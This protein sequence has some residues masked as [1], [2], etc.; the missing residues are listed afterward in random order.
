MI[1]PVF[2]DCDGGGASVVAAVAG[3]EVGSLR[4]SCGT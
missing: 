1:S 2:G 4:P 3:V